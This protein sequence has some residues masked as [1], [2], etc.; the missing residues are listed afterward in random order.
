M[1]KA[2]ILIATTIMIFLSGCSKPDNGKDGAA[3]V[4]GTANV[5]YS[6]WLP[7]GTLSTATIDGNT[8]TVFTLTEPKITQDIIDKGVVLVYLQ[9][10]PT[11][12]FSSLSLPYITGAG[13]GASTIAH[14]TSVGQIK[15]IRF[16]ND[17]VNGATNLGLSWKWR[18]VIIPGGTSVTGKVALKDSLLKMTYEQVCNLYNIAR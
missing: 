18:Y 17:G 13:G 3:G 4:A 7:T 9:I 11:G 2:T 8:G 15:I 1:K 6:P 14:Y 12:D 5:I 10:Q 16:K